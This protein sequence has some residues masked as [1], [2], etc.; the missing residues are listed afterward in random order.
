[1]VKVASHSLRSVFKADYH[2]LADSPTVTAKTGR[3]DSKRQAWTKSVS[4]G[5]VVQV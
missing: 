3:N 4:A 2:Q 1:M 5:G